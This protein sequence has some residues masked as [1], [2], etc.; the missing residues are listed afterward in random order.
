MVKLYRNT[1]MKFIL[2]CLFFVSL[3]LSGC[4]TEPAVPPVKFIDYKEIPAKTKTGE[5]LS[6]DVRVHLQSSGVSSEDKA[7]LE[8]SVQKNLNS[9][10]V[11]FTLKEIL[12]AKRQ[13]IEEQLSHAIVQAYSP[14]EGSDEESLVVLTLDLLEVQ[15]PETLKKS[16]FR[17][18]SLSESI[19]AIRS[20]IQ[21][22]EGYISQLNSMRA[23]PTKEQQMLKAK[24]YLG[25]LKAQQRDS[26]A[27]YKNLTQQLGW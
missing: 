7:A 23:S 3:I 24:L 15:M 16:V 10:S 26:I 18:M 9:I 13:K 14:K 4:A 1:V 17:H 22:Q 21:H 19:M 20:R 6:F 11:Q 8:L 25:K 5:A 12:S 27:E 2:T